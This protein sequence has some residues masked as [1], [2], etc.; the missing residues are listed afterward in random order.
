MSE[1]KGAFPIMY[2]LLTR[3]DNMER[4]YDDELLHVAEERL[5]NY[6]SAD[7]ISFEKVAA[8]NDIDLTVLPKE[9]IELE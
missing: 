4:I 9:D 6:T 2:H 8:K 5:K 1:K 3:P 7:T